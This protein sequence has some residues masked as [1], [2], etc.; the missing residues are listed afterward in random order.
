M[1][2]LFTCAPVFQQALQKPAYIYW[3]AECGRFDRQTV[4]LKME[5][6][7]WKA[8]R[9]RCRLRGEHHLA[10]WLIK[11]LFRSLTDVETATKIKICIKIC[12]RASIQQANAC[13]CAPSVT[14]T[15]TK[16]SR[17][18]PCLTFYYTEFNQTNECRCYSM[19]VLAGM[20]N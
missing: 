19:A 3:N 9:L 6:F 14:H 1:F 10:L 20:Y 11:D 12:I 7:K 5:S 16:N 15:E 4:H 18:F 13:T 2:C 8:A 17:I